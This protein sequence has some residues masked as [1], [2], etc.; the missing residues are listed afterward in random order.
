MNRNCTRIKNHLF[1]NPPR[2]VKA[3]IEAF[4]TPAVMNKFGISIGSEHE[5][6][7]G[8][9]YREDVEFSRR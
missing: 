3:V 4:K 8:G 2:C 1:P 9:D 5:F 6:Y 7:V